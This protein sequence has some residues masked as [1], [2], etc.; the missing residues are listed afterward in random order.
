MPDILASDAFCGAFGV[1]NGFYINDEGKVAYGRMEEGWKQTIELLADWYAEGLLN[2]DFITDTGDV[3]NS[4]VL[5]GDG[6]AFYGLTG[7]GIGVYMNSAA[8][9]GNTDFQLVGVPYPTLEEGATPEFGHYDNPLT[10]TISTISPSSEN[11]EAA[12][13]LLD[14]GYSEAGK[15]LM[16]FGKEGESFNMVDGVPT[17]TDVV[18]KP[19]GGISVGQGIARVARSAY[20]GP[21]VQDINY[22]LQYLQLDCQ[23]DAVSTW[24]A[25]NAASHKLPPVSIS[26]EDSKEY[27]NIIT[28]VNAFVE[29]YTS[30]AIS[31][32][33]DLAAFEDEYVNV[34][35]DIGIERAIE[36]Y[37]AAY[38]NYLNR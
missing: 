33:R 23:K 31:G 22:M 18:L 7:S 10:G 16:N 9:A 28:E 2:P 11:I 12:I 29:E 34:L 27:N 1:S 8:E 4:K 35:K 3:K 25:T 20:G 6:G 24:A 15:N 21:F 36:I 5:N 26:E 32:E 38:D 14:Y 17:Y 19:E 13:R 30:L 37:Q